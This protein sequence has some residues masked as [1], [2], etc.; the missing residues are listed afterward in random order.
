MARRRAILWLCSA[1][2]IALP[3][4]AQTQLMRCQTPRP[5]LCLERLNTT[6]DPSAL[7]YCR[8][9]VN[10]Y[11]AQVTRYRICLED[12]L[13]RVQAEQRRAEERIDCHNRGGGICP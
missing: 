5:P 7:A 6:S 2:L 3:A 4:A 10:A 12:E 11:R 8:N 13:S 1:A 9:D